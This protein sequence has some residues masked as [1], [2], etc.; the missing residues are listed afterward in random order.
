MA[1][2][3]YDGTSVRDPKPIII[4]VTNGDLRFVN[5]S[6]VKETDGSLT[7]AYNAIY[8]TTRSTNTS[9]DTSNVTTYN[10]THTTSY[11]TSRSTTHSTS[12]TT[13]HSTTH[14][15]S[16]NTSK[17]TS[18]SYQTSAWQSYGTH[19]STSHSTSYVTVGYQVHNICHWR[20]CFPCRVC[21]A[22]QRLPLLPS[23]MLWTC[24]NALRCS[25][26]A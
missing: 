4:K 20:H 6:M 11:T 12:Y 19:K 18:T 15:T 5:Y 16:Y 10:T 22:R 23:R 14:S 1:I 7:T 21:W 26:L 17:S 25:R 8:Q 9:Y 2:K 24:S 3:I 13:N